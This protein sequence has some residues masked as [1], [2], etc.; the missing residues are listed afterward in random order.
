MCHAEA[1]YLSITSLI[2]A[3]GL[4]QNTHSAQH[5]LCWAVSHDILVVE[6]TK[7]HSDRKYT[8]EHSLIIQNTDCI[9]AMK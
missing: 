2:Q 3:H 5:N 9:Q 4:F 7:D 1:L 8:M 6:I